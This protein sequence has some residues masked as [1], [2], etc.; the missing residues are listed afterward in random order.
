[1][2]FPPDLYCLYV[3]DLIIQLK[4]LNIGC[5]YLNH[6][7]AVF[8]YADDMC[9]LAPSI[10]GLE[11]MLRLCE[12]YCI[13]WDIGLNAK[14]SRNLYFGK[15]KTITHD[16]ILNKVDWADEWSYLGVRLKSDKVFSCSV[17]ERIKKFYRCA[18]AILRIYG[19]SND[20]VML[21]LIETHCTPL[22]TYAIEIVHVIS[23]DEKRQLRVA[24]NS[25]F[26]KIFGYRWSESVTNLQ[27]FLSRPTWEELV[28][29]RKSRFF[30]RLI[31]NGG[32]SLARVTLV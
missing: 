7:A 23:R 3:D 1:M 2:F 22:L 28:E 15:K 31:H 11:T 16:I 26:R 32:D 30:A 13:E 24:Y 17:T 4:K 25:T 5:H 9:V 10:K 8:F 18:N 6:F 29:R 20:L 21:R 19:R 12:S 14:K 27:S